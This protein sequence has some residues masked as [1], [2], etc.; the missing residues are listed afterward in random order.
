MGVGHY[1]FNKAINSMVCN[2]LVVK[3]LDIIYGI[4]TRY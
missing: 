1:K 4:S 3:D 2:I